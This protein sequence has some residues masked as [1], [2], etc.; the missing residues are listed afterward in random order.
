ME[1]P[2]YDNSNNKEVLDKLKALPVVNCKLSVDQVLLADEPVITSRQAI[3]LLAKHI[4]DSA[5]ETSHAIFL[6]SG[7]Y[8][9]CAANVGVGTECNTLFSARDIAQIALLCNASRVILVHNHPATMCHKRQ[10]TASK[11]DIMMT[12]TV[13]KALSIFGIG[14]HDSIVVSSVADEAK[15]RYPA[16]YSLREKSAF[17]RAVMKKGI[18]NLKPAEVEDDIHWDLTGQEQWRLPGVPKETLESNLDIVEI[19]MNTQ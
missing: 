12:D 13:G 15:Q 2:N 5:R 6:D 16:Y 9:I 7:C 10:L 17:R 8:P 18:G 14:L 1:N 3:M 19:K 11:E 4:H